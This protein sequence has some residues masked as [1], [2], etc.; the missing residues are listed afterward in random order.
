MSLSASNNIISNI[1]NNF[2]NT[3]KWKNWS[4][5]LVFDRARRETRLYSLNKTINNSWSN[6]LKAYKEQIIDLSQCWWFSYKNYLDTTIFKAS[7]C[8]KY[9]NKIKRLI[10]ETFTTN[11]TGKI[12]FSFLFFELIQINKKIS[13]PNKNDQTYDQTDQINNYMEWLNIKKM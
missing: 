13:R 10:E 1:Q 8:P 4:Q 7:V 6:N 12:L 11:M 2:R 9:R 3:I 5:H